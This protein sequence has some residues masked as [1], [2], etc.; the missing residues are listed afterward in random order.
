MAGGWGGWHG[1]GQGHLQ[2]KTIIEMISSLTFI[3][4][5]RIIKDLVSRGPNRMHIPLWGRGATGPDQVRVATAVLGQG[6][7]NS[8]RI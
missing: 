2:G 5:D 7:Y 3:D 6:L 1:H 8:R 4:K